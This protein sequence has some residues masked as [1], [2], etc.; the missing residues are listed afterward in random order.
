[1][2]KAADNERIKLRATYYNNVSVG[3]LLAGGLIPYLAFFRD[4]GEFEFRFSQMWNG[5]APVTDA[6][7]KKLIGGAMAVIAAFW[8]AR[9]TRRWADQEIEKIID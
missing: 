7:L 5:I 8:G 2:G 6:E 1:M 9:L 3:L 4:A